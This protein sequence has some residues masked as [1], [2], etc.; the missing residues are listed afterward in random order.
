M[1]LG[2]RLLGR[3]VLNNVL[4]LSDTE[5][6]F[7]SD[8]EEGAS[9]KT[10]VQEDSAVLAKSEHVVSCNWEDSKRANKIMTYPK[11]YTFSSRE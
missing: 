6:H 8:V 11:L 10:N 5:R 7:V 9:V 3:L 1:L 4:D 2:Q